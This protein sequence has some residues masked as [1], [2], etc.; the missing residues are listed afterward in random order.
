MQPSGV[1]G[2]RA[3]HGPPPL[4]ST[5]H[6]RKLRQA[7]AAGQCRWADHVSRR[8]A[9]YSQQLLRILGQWRTSQTGLAG[10][11]GGGAVGGVSLGHGQA[12]GP[13]R[14]AGKPPAVGSGVLV[15]P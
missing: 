10:H 12:G 9:G 15:S 11:G 13:G 2:I 1:G 8:M 7:G 14:E 6:H 3:G 5:L 4:G